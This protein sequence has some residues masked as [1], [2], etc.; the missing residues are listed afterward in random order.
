MIR[1]SFD[2]CFEKNVNMFFPDLSMT[3]ENSLLNQVP[4][5]R[6]R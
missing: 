2:Y 6:V 1:Y 4:F 5:R 3:Q